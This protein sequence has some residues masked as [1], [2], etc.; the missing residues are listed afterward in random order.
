MTNAG[1]RWLHTPPPNKTTE[2]MW[3]ELD[4]GCA[5][6]SDCLNADIPCKAIEN[7]V[8]HKH[9]KKRI[10]NYYEFTQSVQPWQF[11]TQAGD[12]D[13]KKKRT[14]W[15]LHNLPKL[16]PLGILDGSTASAD[17]HLA[18]PSADR[19]KIRSKS[20]A[21]MAK[22]AALTWGKAAAQFSKAV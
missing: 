10:E 19:W 11:S 6:F 17:V 16:E 14:C 8:M 21:G 18:A 7:P 2:Q 5:L 12:E 13:D 4:E 9:A 1:V 20:H 22:V 15:W 3:K